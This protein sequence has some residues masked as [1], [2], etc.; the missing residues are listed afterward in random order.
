MRLH[1]NA[2]LSVKGRKLLVERIEAGWSVAAAAEAAGFSERTAR[3]WLARF[4]VEGP[5][6]LLDRFSAPSVVANELTS[7]RPR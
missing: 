3:K 6:G 2:K 4:R 1:G 7:A 5:D